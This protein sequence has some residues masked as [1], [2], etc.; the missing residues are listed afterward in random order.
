VDWTGPYRP[1][2]NRSMLVVLVCV[3]VALVLVVMLL[4]ARRALRTE[5]SG[6]VESRVDDDTVLWHDATFDEETHQ[7]ALRALQQARRRAGAEH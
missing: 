6:W 3:V 4:L 7:A 5:H 2:F 1:R